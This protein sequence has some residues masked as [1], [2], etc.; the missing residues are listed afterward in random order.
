MDITMPSCGGIEATR[1]IHELDRALHIVIYSG[2]GDYGNIARAEEAGAAGF[3]H[4]DAVASAELAR[5]A[6]TSCTRTSSARTTTPTTVTG[7]RARSAGRLGVAR[8]APTTCPRA[9]PGGLLSPMSHGHSSGTVARRPRTRGPFACRERRTPTRAGSGS[10]LALIVAFMVAEVVAGILAHSLAL[11][12]DAAHMLTDAG[13]LLLSLVVLRLVRRPAAGQPHLRAAAHWRSC[14]RRRTAPRCSCS[15]GLI[16]FGAIQ[17][18]STPPHP[19]AAT[20][21]VVA[22]AGIVVN[23]ARDAAARAR[24]TATR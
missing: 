23:L 9:A 1:M 12:S 11:L 22:L 24:R 16:V 21:L 13:A 18:L 5:R 20:I 19:T 14:R 2:S 7:A 10:A 6:L 17:R 3:L 15:A 8:K 4:K